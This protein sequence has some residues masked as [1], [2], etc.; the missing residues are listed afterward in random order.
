LIKSLHF[1]DSPGVTAVKQ[2]LFCLMKD[3]TGFWASR[4]FPFH[5]MQGAPVLKVFLTS[6]ASYHYSSAPGWKVMG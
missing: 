4:K 6:D 2:K 5:T 1:V 3:V